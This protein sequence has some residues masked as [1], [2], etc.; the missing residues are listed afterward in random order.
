LAELSKEA[1]ELVIKSDEKAVT[2]IE[3]EIDELVTELYGLSHEEL[4]SLKEQL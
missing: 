2:K 4:Q 1:H 3:K